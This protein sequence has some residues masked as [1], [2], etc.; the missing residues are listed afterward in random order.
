MKEFKCG[1][2]VPG[3]DVVISGDTVWIGLNAGNYDDEEFV[4]W[5]API[6]GGTVEEI[7]R[8]KVRPNPDASDTWRRFSLAVE[9]VLT[10]A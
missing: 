1:D 4:V 10:T 2:V 3:C 6:V 5:R 8:T 9:Q 7:Y